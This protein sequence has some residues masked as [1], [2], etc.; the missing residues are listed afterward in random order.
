MDWLGTIPPPMTLYAK[1]GLVA[2][3]LAAGVF[4]WAAYYRGLGW[5][6]DVGES[7][8]MGFWDWESRAM[9]DEQAKNGPDDKGNE[10]ERPGGYLMLWGIVIT[11]FSV[12]AYLFAHSQAVHDPDGTALIWTS[13]MVAAGISMFLAGLGQRKRWWF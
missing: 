2:I 8:V 6:D 3:I 12:P 7:R 13:V 1:V 10:Q 11:A 5:N 9:T 4:L